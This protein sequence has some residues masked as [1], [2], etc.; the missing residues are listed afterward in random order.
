MHTDAYIYAHTYK[1]I[2]AYAYNTCVNTY[3]HTSINECIDRYTD[4]FRFI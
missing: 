1:C 4:I 3:K 2:S